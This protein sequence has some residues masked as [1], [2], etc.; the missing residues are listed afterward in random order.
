MNGLISTL[1]F[2]CLF[3]VI[4]GAAVGST[5]R[6][7][8]RGRVACSSMYMVVWGG[9][10]GGVP[11]VLGYNLLVPQGGILYFGIELAVLFGTIALVALLPDWFVQ[12]FDG[13]AIA[14]VALGG[15]FLL[16]GLA[17]GMSTFAESPLTALGIG[18]LFAG[19]GGLVFISAVVRAIKG[20]VD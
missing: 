9:F 10:F 4:G 17:V 15:I 14:P 5:V 3:H 2:V 16:T 20:N 6:G 12:S 11:L 8:L 1:A 13:R 19:V 18:G 7:W